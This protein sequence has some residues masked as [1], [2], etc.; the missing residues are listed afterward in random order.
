MKRLIIFFS[1]ALAFCSGCKKLEESPRSFIDPDNFYKTSADAL[2]GLTAAYDPLSGQQNILR[3]ADWPTDNIIAAQVAPADF[4]TPFIFNSGAP[5]F[6]SVWQTEYRGINAANMVLARVPAI[7]MDA[8]LKSRIVAEAKF[9]RALYYFYMVRLFG[10]VPLITTETTS[11]EGLN[12]PRAS[13]KQVYA[14]IVK[15]LTEAESDLPPSFS[16]ND[17]GRATRLAAKALL[18]KVYLTR[19]SLT[20]VAETTDYTN[21]AAK[22]EEVIASDAFDLWADYQ[23]AF[24]VANRNGKESVF[25]I[26]FKGT[27]ATEG[28][29]MM[30]QVL[31]RSTALGA[32]QNQFQ[33]TPDLLN[34]FVPQDRRRTAGFFSAFNQ[35]GTMVTFNAPRVKKYVDTTLLV[36]SPTASTRTFST[37]NNIYVIRYADVL[38]IAA[39]ALNEANSSPTA[40]AYNYVNKVRARAR[41]GNSA[42][43]PDLAGLSQLQFREAIWQERRLELFV[44]GDRWFDLKRTRKLVPVM[45]ALGVTAVQ[46]KHYYFPIPLREVDTNTAIGQANQNPGY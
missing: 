16:G 12:I 39:E 19:A 32:G 9:L 33:P 35:G 14:Q 40:A 38:L 34:A 15:D 44:E 29:V 36:A 18:A 8:V 26:Q 24:T 13:E 10:G 42:I 45:Q 6:A 25:S 31:P 20:G 4:S 1:L 3:L 27:G 41:N 37:D 46:E 23:D 21:A 11:L 28:N 22:A 43:L 2:A 5:L 30:T 7:V 17:V